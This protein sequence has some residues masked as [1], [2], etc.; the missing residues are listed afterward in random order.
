[1]VGTEAENHTLVDTDTSSRL[2][3]NERLVTP[4]AGRAVGSADSLFR[5]SLSNRA[6]PCPRSCPFPGEVVSGH[7]Q[8]LMDAV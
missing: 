1:M 6:P 8:S 7:I 2:P 5:D 4:G 3:I